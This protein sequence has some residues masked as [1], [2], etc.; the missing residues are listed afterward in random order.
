MNRIN[1]KIKRQ[2]GVRA[3]IKGTKIRP[4]LSVYRSNRFMHAQ[5]ID[6]EACKTIVG[7]SEKH[8]K[9]KL[10][11]KIAKAKALGILLAKKAIDKKIKKVVFDRG[12]YLYHGRISGIATGAREGGL[13][14]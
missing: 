11:G 14:F 13:E 1:R 12:S 6:D 2:I 9:E 4:R 7:V 5:L 3:K 8:L 10:N